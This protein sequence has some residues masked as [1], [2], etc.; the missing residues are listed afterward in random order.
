MI[1]HYRMERIG[2]YRLNTNTH[3]FFNETI[4]RERREETRVS[5]EAIEV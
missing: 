5:R 3:R 4:N 2:G 1:I